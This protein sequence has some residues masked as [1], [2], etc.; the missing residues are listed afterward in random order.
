MSS[1]KL[2]LIATLMPVMLIFTVVNFLF[3]KDDSIQSINAAY[4]RS[5]L[6]VIKSIDRNVSTSSGGLSVE[7]PYQLFEFFHLTASGNVFFRVATTD[8][9]V[10]LG[11]HDLPQPP[12]PLKPGQTIFYDAQ[13]FGEPVRV[14]AFMPHM[15]RSEGK[16]SA[17]QWT[18][19]VAESTQ[20]RATFAASLTHRAL[21]RDGLSL[22]LVSV[23]LAIGLIF[24]LKPL[25][26][27]AQQTKAR[28][29]DDLR[30]LPTEKL[31]SE[32]LP[33][34]FAVNNQFERTEKLMAER[35]SFVDDAS[36]QLRTPLTILRT[37]LDFALRQTDS[38]SKTEALDALAQELVLAIRGTNQLLAL[39]HSDAACV[40]KQEF[41]LTELVRQ[42]ALDL[43]PLASHRGIDLGVEMTESAL[44]ANGD[45]QL[46]RQALTNIV[47]N[48]I[49]HGRINGIVT[50]KAHVHE[51]HPFIKVIDD[52]PGIPTD[53]ADRL[54]QRF[55]K[56]QQSRGSG[57]G[58]SIAKSVMQS[59][60]GKL[61]IVSPVNVNGTEVEM[62]WPPI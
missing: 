34:V 41:N 26:N 11:N 2:R 38:V 6:G 24:A 40:E 12:V 58:L 36:H 42:V 62:A 9:L 52:G 43:L 5:L 23:T 45:S 47:H 57:L 35:R 21:W 17:S 61:K 22:L 10:E 18:I 14:G 37:Q 30:P 4:D 48:A 32:L 44:P 53:I 19:Q 60:N 3:T 31:P 46:I 49:E 33:L 51:G 13:Y 27:L 15:K 8:G 1:L 16:S 20:S 28:K 55:V 39:A 7:L 54:G 59:H 29:A 50:I 56:G 25:L